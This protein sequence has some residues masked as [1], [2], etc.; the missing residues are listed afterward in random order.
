MNIV[1]I[2]PILLIVVAIITILS[3]LPESSDKAKNILG[4]SVICMILLIFVMDAPADVIYTDLIKWDV[5]VLIIF[6]TIFVDMLDELRYFEYIGIHLV[7][8]TKGNQSKLFLSLGVMMF[9]MS[10]FLDNVTAII[11]LSTLTITVCRRLEISPVP[12]LIY[13]TFLTGVGALLTPVG[14]VPN[15]ILNSAARIP[16][17]RWVAVMLVFSILSLIISSFYF[18]YIY[19]S[20]LMP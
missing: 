4:G 18:K 5:L 20:F 12:Y 19:K 6:L 9:F 16:F 17:G 10:A 7:K 11:L 13:E 14:S 2:G 8:F 1:E 3:I 15:I